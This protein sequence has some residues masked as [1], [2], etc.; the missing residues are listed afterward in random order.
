M[1]M[2]AAEKQKEERQRLKEID[3]GRKEQKAER[4]RKEKEI[5]RRQ[6]EEDVQRKVQ[7]VE[8]ECERQEQDCQR[9]AE[10]K[11][12]RQVENIQA[13]KRVEVAVKRSPSVSISSVLPPAI[14]VRSLLNSNCSLSTASCA[15]L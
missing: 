12:R 14:C 9:A 4:Q 11:R 6:Q 7:V 2:E 5:E 15:F 8:E 10:L 3:C 1:A 13:E